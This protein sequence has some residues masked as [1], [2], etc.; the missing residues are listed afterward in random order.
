MIRIITS[1][2]STDFTRYSPGDASS[3]FTLGKRLQ[4]LLPGGCPRKTK[5]P[6]ALWQFASAVA[7]KMK[8]CRNDST[9]RLSIGQIAVAILQYV[10]GQQNTSSNRP[11]FSIASGPSPS[12]D[13]FHTREQCVRRLHANL[14]TYGALGSG[15]EPSDSGAEFSEVDV[16]VESGLEVHYQLM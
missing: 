15:A 1:R 7:P 9:Y 6:E 3:E 12:A 5:A 10:V 2:K 16:G 8:Y 14:Q 11:R 4:I 13:E